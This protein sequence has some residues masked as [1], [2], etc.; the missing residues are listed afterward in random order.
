MS[1]VPGKRIKENIQALVKD[2][3]QRTVGR[4]MNL[5][6]T[7]E[8]AAYPDAI[9]QAYGIEVVPDAQENRAGRLRRTKFL[10]RT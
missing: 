2:F 8:Y 9:L 7:D 6:T 1:V 3:K 10:R 5:I 4:M